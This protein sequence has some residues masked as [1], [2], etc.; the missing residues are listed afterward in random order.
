MLTTTPSKPTLHAAIMTL[1]LIS[2]PGSGIVNVMCLV[3]LIW[4]LCELFCMGVKL[5]R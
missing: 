4:V 2:F 1:W 3:Y 5:G